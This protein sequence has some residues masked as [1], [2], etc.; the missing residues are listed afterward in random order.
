MK[1]LIF[2][3]CVLCFLNLNNLSFAQDINWEEIG[4]GN[5]GLKCILVQDKPKLIYFG[6]SKGVFK[7]E[8]DGGSFRNVL[9]VRGHNKNINFLSFD[10]LDKNSIYAGTGNGLFRSKSQGK[11]WDRIFKGKNYLENECTALLISPFGIYL[12]TKAGLFISKDHGRSWHREKAKLG[13][14]P[15]YGLSGNLKESDYI[16]AACAD[17][18][19]ASFD[20]GLTWERSFIATNP[21][22]TEEAEELSDDTNDDRG[23]FQ[24]RYIASGVNNLSNL[25]LA[26]SRGAYKSA[27]KGKTWEAISNY[28]LFSRDIKFLLAT[29]NLEIYAATKSGVFEYRNERWHE[30]SFGLT[31]QDIEFLAR[32]NQV[33]L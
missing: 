12:G 21:I 33:N 14:S 24:I 32:Y 5:S 26:T 27:D 25:Y 23:Y 22:N 6:S 18:V 10:P 13:K 20:K 4:R 8:D 17:G 15:I 9:S 19:F 16:Y 2:N 1:N 31:A 29:N 3:L 7:S 28:G 11:N 30:L